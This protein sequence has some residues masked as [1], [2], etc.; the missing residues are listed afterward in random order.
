MAINPGT[1]RD[2]D[3]TI[4]DNGFDRREAS[5]EEG[6]R[7]GG[8]VLTHSWSTQSP[9]RLPFARVYARW[10]ISACLPCFCVCGAWD[11][12]LSIVWL[13][14]CRPGHGRVPTLRQSESSR[15]RLSRLERITR[16]SF[17]RVLIA[18][19]SLSLKLNE[20]V[21]EQEDI[22]GKDSEREQS[23]FSRESRA[24]K[25]ILVLYFC[26]SFISILTRKYWDSLSLEGVEERRIKMWLDYGK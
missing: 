9:S 2:Y 6:G 25:G 12:A 7:G 17:R 3:T 23:T 4:S 14:Y 26:L 18:R 20:L 8:R 16:R 10:S 1:M 15:A 21:L 13:F 22:S 5:I 24:N 11:R 19:R